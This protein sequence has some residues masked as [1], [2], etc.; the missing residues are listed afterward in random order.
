MPRV[1]PSVYGG[2]AGEFIA[3]V[4]L[5]GIPHA[6]G[7]PTFLLLVKAL[8]FL[9][10]FGNLIYQINL[11]SAILASSCLV[12]CYF[13]F[14][15][16]L[17]GQIWLPL[18]GIFILGTSSI[19]VDQALAAEVFGLNL[20]F[21]I[22]ILLCLKFWFSSGEL[23][24]NLNCLVLA[25]FLMGL[26]LGNHH[27]LVFVGPLVLLGILFRE[28]RWKILTF[29]LLF[30][31]LGFSI[32]F[33]LPIRAQMNPPVNFGDPETFK[34]FFSVLTRKEFGSLSLHPAAVPFYDFGLLLKQCGVFLKRTGDQ[35]GF[36]GW[37]ILLA[38]GTPLLIS[39]KTRRTAF[40]F[41]SG[42]LLVGFGFEIL[43]NM[44]PGS[45]IGQWRMNRFFLLP[46]FSMVGLIMLS[47]SWGL[48]N[49][50]KIRFLFIGLLSLLIL[51]KGMG[52]AQLPSLRHNQVFRD[53]AL[54]ALRDVPK[55]A[56]V[57]IDRVL[58]DEPT[59]SL[60]VTTQVENKRQDIDFYYRPGTLFKPV[61]G[62]DILDLSW[63]N[64][65][66]RQTEV[67]KALMEK[68][69]RPMAF[70]AFEGK[71]SPFSPAQLGGLLYLKG[72][73]PHDRPQK[74]AENLYLYRM[75]PFS[76]LEDYQGKL[77]AVHFSYLLAKSFMESGQTEKAW[78]WIQWTLAYGGEM[79]WLLTNLG[80]LYA[81]QEEFDLAHRYYEKAIE[82]DPYFF[83][84]H[85]GLGYTHMKLNQ[86]GPAVESYRQAVRLAPHN[87]DGYY[88][89]GVGYYELGQK[90][91]AR[92]VWRRFLK[93]TP[94]DPKS[95]T[96][97]SL[98]NT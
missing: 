87:P 80:S 53:F 2:D 55:N 72:P 4:H 98:L 23:I 74:R 94:N 92:E 12:L 22:S 86:L 68:G 17:R 61:Y 15:F 51:E 75:P 11:I 19:F 28:N 56:A 73:Q 3:S 39:R 14:K 10:P 34:R 33:Y 40:I 5:L 21:L 71:N 65:Y 13:L 82:R 66:R 77:M 70:L 81:K 20:I 25:S 45:A 6:P 64:R 95:S 69:S 1:S 31:I 54:S 41:L 27:I 50:G 16:L 35:I 7:F 8:S 32:Y 37:A 96:I 48:L 63:E 59:S 57:I 78:P 85:Y 58:F 36:A 76:R 79:A 52:W 93:L 43:S 90:E 24:S 38:G 88:M 26:G 29:S 91:E 60:L 97:R 84:G 89:L 42:Y 18:L 83:Q 44:S 30:G 62:E 49:R 47:L 67:E 46:L 9:I